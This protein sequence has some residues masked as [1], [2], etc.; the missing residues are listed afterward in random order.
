LKTQIQ[1]PP[2]K[3]AAALNFPIGI[4]QSKQK[5]CV[6]RVETRSNLKVPTPLSLVVVE[7]EDEEEEDEEPP[8]PITEEEEEELQ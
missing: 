5:A 2:R 7:E 3:A 4:V 8:A 1:R 6:M